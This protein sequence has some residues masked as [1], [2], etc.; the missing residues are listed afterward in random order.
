MR[1]GFDISQTGQ[2]KAGCGYFAYSLI[3]HLADIDSENQYILYP[4]FGDLYLDPD[5]PNAT[6]QI[7]RPNFQRGLAHRTLEA[8]QHFWSKPPTDLEQRL[9][10]PDIIHAN[11][12]FCPTDLRK[13]RL[14]YTFY[15]L[16]FLEHP[17]W[18]TE[19]NRIACF[20]GAFHASLY[21]DLV[22]AISD[23]SRRHFLEMFPHFPEE[24]AIVIY[25]ASRFTI[26]K[27]LGKTDIA[28]PLSPDQFW[29]S[30]GTLEP[31]KNHASLLQ[32]YARLKTQLGKTFPLVFVGAHGWMMDDFEKRIAELNLQ[33]DV[34]R[35][36]YVD[37]NT[38]Q[39][40]Y[41]NCFAFVFPSLFEGFGLPVLE[42]MSLGAPVIASGLTS[43]PEIVD[44]AGILIDP[45]KDEAIYQAMLQ[46]SEDP[47]LGVRLAQKAVKQASK[48]NWQAAACAV[49]ECYKE[50]HS[51]PQKRY[52]ARRPPN[53][54]VW[55]IR[56]P[57]GLRVL[58]G[59]AEAKLSFLVSKKVVCPICLSRLNYLPIDSEKSHLT[60]N[61]CGSSFI[62][63][64]DVPI[65]LID[66]ENLRKK[67][68]E[69]KG[70]AEYNAKHIP[71][72]VHTARNAFVNRNTQLF[73]D[74]CE[75]DF[76]GKEILIVGCSMAELE[77]F[78][79][80]TNRIVCLDLVPALTL[81]CRRATSEKGFDAVW[82]CGDGE[83]LPFEEE[84]FDIVIVRQAL[85]HMLKYYSAVSE[86][87][88]VCKI[89][90]TVLIVDE[91]FSP[92]DL[93]DE[94]LNELPDDFHVYKDISL[95]HIRKRTGI[96]RGSLSYDRSSVKIGRLEKEQPYITPDSGRPETYLADK[97]HCFSLLNCVYAIKLHTDQLYLSWPREIAWIDE[98]SEAPKLCCRPNP[99]LGDPLVE[100]LAS[101]GNVS[102]YAR[103]LKKTTCFRNRQG[104]RAVSL[105]T[106][107]NCLSAI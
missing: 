10:S 88:R 87:F 53:Q 38:L 52:A 91:V 19:Q 64:V 71:M 75:I 30:V 96:S 50:L 17:D 34:L 7:K 6:C 3:S 70:E 86:L 45:L 12:F 9:G 59:L 58:F 107:V 8:A 51:G 20:T 35:I 93:H 4:T 68:D 61:S 80:K 18:T 2:Y 82:M 21:A 41:Q 74:E 103:K 13:A 81:A 25:P 55:Q 97:Y 22:V 31:R 77:L 46:L 11:N 66:D 104:I 44:D 90:G 16:S 32:A 49:L 95:G 37:D 100:K 69:I 5:W 60:C 105:D 40:L 27:D 78:A 63:Q 94:A 62:V 33:Q 39:W 89:G 15:D 85:H 57:L 24:Q 84:S 99:H 76:S 102:I 48:F 92:L 43:I 47:S 56:L 29:L 36:G 54:T 67:L 14:V 42:A 79:P 1:I 65:L 101:P 26:K 106:V 98:G 28:Q 23:Y 72:K 83:C 73:L